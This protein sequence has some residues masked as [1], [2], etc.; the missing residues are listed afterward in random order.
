VG[1]C[2]IQKRAPS[3][4]RHP[5]LWVCT[6]HMDVLG[7]LWTNTAQLVQVCP[8]CHLDP[9]ASTAALCYRNPP[10]VGWRGGWG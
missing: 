7:M 6:K 1:G 9:E 10:G 4:V 5:K 3:Y 8:A 2:R